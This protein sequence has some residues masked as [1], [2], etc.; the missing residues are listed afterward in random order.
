[1]TISVGG[2]GHRVSFS[3]PRH[4]DLAGRPSSPAPSRVRRD[5]LGERA[6]CGNLIR[7]ARATDRLRQWVRNPH[8]LNGRA[9]EKYSTG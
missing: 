9:A 5:T 8:C 6:Q 1:M 2:S 3:D 7:T 4:E